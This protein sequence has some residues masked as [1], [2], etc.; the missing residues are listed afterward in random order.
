MPLS[1][2]RKDFT[3]R[4]IGVRA[5]TKIVRCA[6]ISANDRMSQAV[7]LGRR[8]SYGDLQQSQD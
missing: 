7:M 1:L 3:P 4:N 5:N 8:F 2:C 6:E